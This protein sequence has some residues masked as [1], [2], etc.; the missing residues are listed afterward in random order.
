L[1]TIATLP[2][3]S[4]P[5]SEH[6]RARIVARTPRRSGLGAV[7]IGEAV[8]Y[9]DQNTGRT[10]R[11]RVVPLRD[12]DPERGRISL[13]SP[14]GAALLGLSVGQTAEWED[15]RGNRRTLRVLR[16]EEDIES[17]GYLDV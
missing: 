2:P 4:P 14:V 17:V 1:K 8:V 9:H 10:R 7:D 6:E 13:Q 3:F 12:V 15:R 5:D 11:V 16:I